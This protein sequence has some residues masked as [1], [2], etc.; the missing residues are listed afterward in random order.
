MTLDDCMTIADAAKRLKLSMSRV[1]QLVEDK[2]LETVSIDRRT[3]L[4]TKASVERE[5][6]SRRRALLEKVPQ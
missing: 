3:T 4:L 2:T 5:A 6:E 1:R